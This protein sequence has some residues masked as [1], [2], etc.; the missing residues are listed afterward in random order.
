MSHENEKLKARDLR[1]A[2]M[3][4]EN[5]ARLIEEGD[6][7]E[8]EKWQPTTLEDVEW[9]VWQMSE[10]QRQAAAIRKQA[11]RRVEA[12]ERQLAAW[13]ALYG[14][15]MQEIIRQAL[16]KRRRSIDLEL[17]RVGLRAT[18]GRYEVDAKALAAQAVEEIRKGGWPHPAVVDGLKAVIETEWEGVAAGY[19]IRSFPET[20]VTLRVSPIQQW[21]KEQTYADPE[22]GELA[23]HPNPLPGVAW[24][25]PTETLTWSVPTEDKDEGDTNE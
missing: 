2:G 20:Q 21:A 14:A 18:P 24:K 3:P 25:P 12:I 19:A 5:I 11:E 23:P 17:C 9:I 1:A 22:T 10:K 7:E 13:E 4:E 16:P 15:A 8:G 6:A